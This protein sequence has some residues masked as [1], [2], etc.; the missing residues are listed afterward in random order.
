MEQ[1]TGLWIVPCDAIHIFF[2][3]MVIDSI[4]LDKNLR[5]TKVKTGRSPLSLKSW[6][7][8]TMLQLTRTPLAILLTLAALAITAVI[9]DCRFQRIPN[10]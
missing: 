1:S 2:I 10:W 9:Y 7:P 3:K 6:R 4:S 8:T 5:V